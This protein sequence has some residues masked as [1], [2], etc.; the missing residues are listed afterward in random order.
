MRQ[1][2]KRAEEMAAKPGLPAEVAAQ[3]R[4]S[5]ERYRQYLKMAEEGGAEVL[6]QEYLSDRANSRF[7]MRVAPAGW[8]KEHALPPWGFPQDKVSADSL[9]GVYERFLI[10]SYDK[11]LGDSFRAW[12]GQKRDDNYLGSVLA[13]P[14]DMPTTYFP[15][16]AVEDQSW[17][18]Q[19]HPVDEFFAAPVDQM[20]VTGRA[21]VD[22]R[23]VYVLERLWRDPY[24]NSF[25]PEGRLRE[26]YKDRYKHVFLARALVDPARGCMPLQITWDAYYT[27]DGRTT[28]PPGALP[29]L[30]LDHV[31]VDQVE[32]AG[33][34]PVK[35][36][37]HVSGDDESVPIDFFSSDTEYEKV[38]TGQRPLR[39]RIWTD[40]TT[41]Q[42]GRLLV[43]CTVPEDFIL[44]FPD[45]TLYADETR[46]K[47]LLTG[48]S[49]TLLDKAIGPE[50][51]QQHFEPADLTP[52]VFTWLLT[53]NLVCLALLGSWF[54]L[55]RRASRRKVA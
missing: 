21:A 39:P 1:L 40:E 37:L 45:K 26:K 15:P 22:G 3:Q 50:G 10:Y 30:L 8:V 55:R 32:G 49:Q 18:K 4:A 48:E 16:L 51:Q 6:L 31:T 43:N 20:N 54:L 52:P 13:G 14:K 27:L 12:G 34:Y 23:T 38:L 53:G 17:G 29:Q 35:G 5:A 19:W 36:T 28:Q 2:I 24:V 47:T 42:V 25:I 44:A 7:Q 33:Y 46:R 41:W 9:Q 11:S